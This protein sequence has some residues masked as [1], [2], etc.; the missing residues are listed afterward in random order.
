MIDV[1]FIP[2]TNEMR[3][4]ILENGM[5]KFSVYGENPA[6]DAY[7]ARLQEKQRERY[8][9]ANPP[10]ER[11]SVTNSTNRAL[12]DEE[13]KKANLETR[14]RTHIEVKDPAMA[15]MASMRLDADYDGEK[16]RL[17]GTYNKWDAADLATAES[18]I[19]QEI[20][21]ARETDDYH[22]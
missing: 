13:K 10:T 19:K 12:T 18:I 16:Q 4:A 9:Q 14:D 7:M 20:E 11:V 1:P 6:F 22:V 21:K 3:K 5:P 17:F 2:V 15:Q 8:L